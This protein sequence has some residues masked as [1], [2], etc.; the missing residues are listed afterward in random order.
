VTDQSWGRTS[1]EWGDFTRVVV[2][3]YFTIAAMIQASTEETLVERCRFRNDHVAGKAPV[4]LTCN[5]QWSVGSAITP[6]SETNLPFSTGTQST[7]HQVHRG[8]D[9]YYGAGLDSTAS[10]AACLVLHGVNQCRIETPF[11]NNNARLV[12]CVR[13]VGG[14]PDSQ[15]NNVH[16]VGANCHKQLR[17]GM[18]L[19]GSNKQC[20]WTD[21][22]TTIGSAFSDA[23]V[24]I[25][26]FTSALFVN[27]CSSI[28]IQ[29]QLINST[30]LN[31]DTATWDS[32]KYIKA[33]HLDIE[34][35]FTA[36]GTS[37]S[38]NNFDLVF[39]GDSYKIQGKYSAPTSPSADVVITSNKIGRYTRI[40]SNTTAE[41]VE[42]VNEGL[43]NPIR[44][45]V[46]PAVSTSQFSYEEYN[47]G[48][49][50]ECRV[51][52]G[53]LFICDLASGGVVLKSANG[54]Q[55]RLV[56][57]DAGAVSSQLITI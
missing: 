30:V 46:G 5:L 22:S 29:S 45:I 36:T 12:D 52:R 4:L 20:S 17:S 48:A 57:S 35:T 28:S 31:C 11:F 40:A 41:L 51:H 3:K 49:T 39:A 27:R 34:T 33:T 19:V 18:R 23:E 10:E 15:T 7:L 2:D 54:T 44:K 24:V 37:N 50:R 9:Y 16:V 13:V 55:Y 21:S 14:V 42:S 25:E 1:N 43:S 32:T 56:V 6:S 53:G 8:C 38:D 47:R 26:G